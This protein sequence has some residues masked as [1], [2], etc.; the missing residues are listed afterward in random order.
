MART[1]CQER[2]QFCHRA[3]GLSQGATVIHFMFHKVEPCCDHSQVIDMLKKFP[4]P[5]P[6]RQNMS[7]PR[8]SNEDR[9]LWRVKCREKL[10]AHLS[11]SISS[12]DGY[13]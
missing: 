1:L 6:I 7:Q 8:K 11:E 10:S 13:F 2:H 4:C 9:A 12:Y 3:L 5:I